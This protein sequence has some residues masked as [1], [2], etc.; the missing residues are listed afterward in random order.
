MVFA[1]VLLAGGLAAAV[2]GL[3]VGVPSLRL[4]GDY[5]AIVTLG[6][7]EI[8]RVLI[9]NTDAVGGPRGFQRHRGLHD[10]FLDVHGRGAHDL[11]RRSAW[12]IRLTVAVF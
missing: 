5:L 3:I 12:S 11:C 4:K 7:G 1:S 9:Q 6:F 2:A 8:I 10:D